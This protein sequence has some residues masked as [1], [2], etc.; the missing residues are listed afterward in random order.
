MILAG[1]E[2]WLFCYFCGRWLNKKLEHCFSL[3]S[4][5]NLSFAV[6]KLSSEGSD[7]RIRTVKEIK[8][9]I[10]QAKAKRYKLRFCKM[11]DISKLSVRVYADASYPTK[12]EESEE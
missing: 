12:R 4:R 10:K 11:G 1:N 7:E 2:L 9:R 8:R 3:V 6:N 5:L